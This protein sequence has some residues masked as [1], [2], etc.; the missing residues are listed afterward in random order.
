MLVSSGHWSLE[1][2][3]AHVGRKKLDSR[4]P[5]SIQKSWCDSGY[6]DMR[7]VTTISRAKLCFGYFF[8][9]QCARTP[10]TKR[11]VLSG[12]PFRFTRPVLMGIPIWIPNIQLHS[13]CPTYFFWKFGFQTQSWNPAR[14]TKTKAPALK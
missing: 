6:R 2:E 9:S 11:T 10:V 12:I 14:E 5:V 3:P 8:I 1:T 7:C 4:S 13:D